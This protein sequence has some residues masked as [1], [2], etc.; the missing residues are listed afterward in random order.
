MTRTSLNF[1]SFGIC[2]FQK[3]RE[4]QIPEEWHELL[5]CC[6]VKDRRSGRRLN[7]K[8]IFSSLIDL[9]CSDGFR[10]MSDSSFD[11]LVHFPPDF[12][13]TANQYS[14]AQFWV[15]SSQEYILNEGSSRKLLVGS[16]GKNVGG[17]EYCDQS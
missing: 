6:L 13:R 4:K 10:G 14:L 11:H 7:H 3:S 2:E 5:L 17:M 16:P 15:Q 9:V 12:H 1:L 8:D